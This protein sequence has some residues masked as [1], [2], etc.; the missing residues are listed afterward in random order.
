MAVRD[1]R[2]LAALRASGSSRAPVSRRR[3]RTPPARTRSSIQPNRI[4]NRI[5]NSDF[6]DGQCRRCAGPTKLDHRGGGGRTDQRRERAI[7]GQRG[8]ARRLLA[9]TGAGSGGSVSAISQASRRRQARG[10]VQA[11]NGCAGMRREAA[12]RHIGRRMHRR[13]WKRKTVGIHERKPCR[14]RRLEDGRTLRRNHGSGGAN[15]RSRMPAGSCPNF[16]IFALFV[17]SSA[18]SLMHVS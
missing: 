14:N 2:W 16:S 6:Q 18:W 12:R 4:A 9:V 15:S 7:A 13:R 5:R 8:Q 11:H 17:A 1:E 10:Q 3:R